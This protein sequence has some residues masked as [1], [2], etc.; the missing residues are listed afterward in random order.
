MARYG[1]GAMKAARVVDWTQVHHG[2]FH[3]HRDEEQRAADVVG[4][5]DGRDHQQR[6]PERQERGDSVRVHHPLDQPRSRQSPS[7]HCQAAALHPARTAQHSVLRRNCQGCHIAIM[8]GDPAP[9]SLTLK[10][11]QLVPKVS[12]LC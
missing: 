5:G 9:F 12:R 7:A 2:T 8:G 11:L 1:D 10:S 6:R 4:R 3:G